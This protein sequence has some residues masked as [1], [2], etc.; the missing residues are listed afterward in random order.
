MVSLDR[1]FICQVLYSCCSFCVLSLAIVISVICFDIRSNYIGSR[2]EIDG[3]QT[4]GLDWMKQPFVGTIVRVDALDDCPSTHPDEM[5]YDV[6]MGLMEVCFCQT[7][8]SLE[9]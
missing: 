3:A 9:S 1:R 4:I 5:V 7:G 2:I 8:S 6:W